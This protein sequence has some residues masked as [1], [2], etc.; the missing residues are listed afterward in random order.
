[1]EQVSGL[2][3]PGFVGSQFHWWIGQV[4]NSG[5]WR[6]NQPNSFFLFRGDIPGWG[7]RY[8][9][10]IMGIH[11]AGE[12]IIPSDQLPWAQVMYPITAGGGHG[13]SFQTPGIKQGNF[14]FG[15]FLDGSDE[16]IPIIM[17]V[18]GNNAK[19][20]IGEISSKENDEKGF[21]PK[22][23]YDSDTTIA[24]DD[25]LMTEEPSSVATIESSDANQKENAGDKNRKEVMDKE[26]PIECPKHGNTLTS[27]QTHMSNFQKDYQK[28]MSQLNDYG[29]AAASKNIITNINE[30]ARIDA[31]IEKTSKLSAK[32][33][34]PSLNNTHN[35][36]SQKLNDVTKSIDDATSIFDRLDN[37]EANVEAQGKL[38]CVFNKIKGDL[39]R[40]IAAG[41]KKSLAK[42]QNRTPQNVNQTRPQG[43]NS[44]L[45]PPI[46]PEGFY[47]PTN[48]CET[49]D[50]IADVFSNV[51]GDIT[52]G[53]QD[54]ITPLAT[55]TGSSS[56]GRLASVLS[57]ENVITNLE[58]GKLFGGLASALGAG[59]GIS[60]GQSG[61]ITSALKSGNY[62]AAL[63]SL[64]DFSGSNE[65]IG[66]L[67]TALQSIDNGDIVGAFQGLSGPLGIDSKLMGAVGGA[68]GAIKG[69]D[70]GSLTNALGNLGGAAPQILT[71][72]LGG[73]LPLSGID[74]GGFGA[75][76][77]LDFD[78]A[79][80]STFM[81]T[82]AAFLECDPP[83]ECPV[84]DTHTLNGGGKSKD[85]SK[86]EKVNNTNIMNKVKEGVE[87][88]GIPTDL[89]SGSFGIS[90]EG[91]QQALNN[92][93]SDNLDQ[94]TGTP[95]NLP[96]GSFGISAAGREQ[97]LTNRINQGIESTGIAD[98]LQ[99][100]SFGISEAGARE[101]L[102]NRVESQ[103]GIPANLPE[104]SFGI[105]PKKK[106]N[107]PKGGGSVV[108][109]KR[110]KS[111]TG[112][113]N[114]TVKLP[115]GGVRDS[116]TKE[117]ITDAYAELHKRYVNNEKLT[118]EE[119]TNYEY[120][121][122]NIMW[123]KYGVSSSGIQSVLGGGD[124]LDPY[125]KERFG[126]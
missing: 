86:T 8:K 17:G 123:A 10:R 111:D 73:R 42:K 103:T 41:I 50:I 80:A 109:N 117:Q 107:V 77:G 102:T 60:A 63:T 15:F 83:D 100:G 118:R 84:N 5:T 89:P 58:N 49:E 112:K 12:A 31:L 106:F 11:D 98:N 38:G 76:G 87:S 34:T 92:R 64:V 116:L 3:N 20:V 30:Q 2:Y 51:M 79:L 24:S 6:D 65:A 81:S 59:I 18:L 85:Q 44:G 26:T 93:L 124:T 110:T 88:T 96:E 19:T 28:I 122:P 57:Q 105:T 119:K 101:A 62:A 22:S 114:T 61:A 4:A 37:L 90:P 53:Y 40:L 35:F 36:L 48:P 91:A 14:V 39:A 7:Y 82:A 71:D 27:M 113:S 99:P 70:I 54:V 56:Q 72:V 55:G 125:V 52:Q 67:S 16:Q 120:W 74:I 95:L 75:L 121:Y 21:G 32:S 13:G 1:M 23:G 29:T 115:K 66:G 97:A 108:Y 45:I 46:P 69:G 25:Q 43:G 126:K 9:V 78:L 94:V 104:G 47:T 68:L 33:L